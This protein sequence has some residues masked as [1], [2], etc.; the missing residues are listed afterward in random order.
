M[1]Y[2]LNYLVDSDIQAIGTTS[3]N[4]CAISKKEI[5]ERDQKFEQLL[6][7]YT[8]THQFKIQELKEA[9]LLLLPEHHSSQKCYLG[10]VALTAF[11]MSRGPLIVILETERS[12]E[13]AS[14]K[15]LLLSDL[16]SLSYNSS[17]D[18]LYGIGWDNLD[19]AYKLDAEIVKEFDEQN[20]KLT[21]ELLDLSAIAKTKFP[22]IFFPSKEEDLEL[23][24]LAAVRFSLFQ[25]PAR[26][27]SEYYSL[28][29][30]KTLA[31]VDAFLSGKREK[32]H[33]VYIKKELEIF[34]GYH[35]I[36]PSYS[37]I[38]NSYSL[39]KKNRDNQLFAIVAKT[40]PIRTKSMVTTLQALEK[41]KAE[42]KI[43]NAKAVLIAGAKHL[44]HDGEELIDPNYDISD[45]HDELVH[46]KAVILLSKSLS[47]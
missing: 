47:S 45:L 30:E 2:V 37:N 3:K 20:S 27:K 16:Q 23:Q 18:N 25:P 39:L 4:M 9:N 42:H 14:N 34:R 19:E 29:L 24:G 46:H 7:S 41:F 43:P 11:L 5:Q 6:S 32:K 8:V 12:M 28:Y 17:K 21:Q 35:E 40:F 1:K 44:H 26:Y 22:E 31:N 13:K 33:R 38:N 10:Q 15:S 36:K